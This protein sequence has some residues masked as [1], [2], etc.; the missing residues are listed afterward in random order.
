MKKN[1]SNI[2]LT[3]NWGQKTVLKLFMKTFA[4]RRRYFS[5]S[6]TLQDLS[7]KG[8]ES[9]RIFFKVIGS[10]AIIFSDNSLAVP[11]SPCPWAE[12]PILLDLF[13]S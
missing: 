4:K 3:D 12:I 6:E 2:V 11:S 13:L 8:N 5:G 7:S 10:K 1:Q 9:F